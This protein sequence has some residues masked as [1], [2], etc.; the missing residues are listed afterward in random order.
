MQAL[1]LSY[2]IGVDREQER[3]KLMSATAARVGL[4]MPEYAEEKDGS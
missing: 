2:N 4:R 3:R 1:L